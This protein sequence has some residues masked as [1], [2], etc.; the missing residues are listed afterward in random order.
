MAGQGDDRVSDNRPQSVWVGQVSANIAIG[1]DR[2]LPLEM[3][4]TITIPL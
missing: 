4:S 3:V 1:T 2:M